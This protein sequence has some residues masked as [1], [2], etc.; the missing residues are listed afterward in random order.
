MALS[1]DLGNG[2]DLEVFQP[3]KS[4]CLGLSDSPVRS[5]EEMIGPPLPLCVSI[6]MAHSLRALYSPVSLADGSSSTVVIG[7]GRRKH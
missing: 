6:V 5:E 2:Q 1:R 7:H 4:F 3:G